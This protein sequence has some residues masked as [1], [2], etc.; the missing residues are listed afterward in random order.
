[1]SFCCSCISEDGV[2]RTLSAL[3]A[4]RTFSEGEDFSAT[5]ISAGGSL[6]RYMSTEVIS[7]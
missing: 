6:C 1:M 3:R 4:D 5:K 7:Q 2:L